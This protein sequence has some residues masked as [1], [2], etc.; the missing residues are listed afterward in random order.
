MYFAPTGVHSDN[1]AG[2]LAELGDGNYYLES[3]KP[4]YVFEFRISLDD[5]VIEDDVRLTPANGMRIPFEPMIH[6]NDGSGME[7]IMVLSPINDDNAHQTCEVWSSTW[8]GDRSTVLS[9]EEEIVA[10]EFALH[11]NYPNPFNPETTI[12][13]S[14]P[15][16]QDVNLSVYN[17]LG[18][19]V[20][21]LYSGELQGGN[22]IAK[23]HAGDIASGV[24]IY[25]LTSSN[26]TL[27]QK[28]L[29]L[30]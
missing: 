12:K 16:T 19:R 2:M 11:Q 17:M 29:L 20:V 9:N 30:K 13:F 7:A 5:L 24:Y 27:T 3:F 21:T 4:D 18:Q 26:K 15:N 10:N 14:I 6:D 22:H 28:M 25:K 8:I 23:W 1:G